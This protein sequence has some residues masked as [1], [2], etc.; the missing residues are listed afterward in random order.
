MS[1]GV[2]LQM[3]VDATKRSSTSRVVGVKISRGIIEFASRQTETQEYVVENKSDREK[4]V[5]VEH[6]RR[7][8]DWKLVETP[9]PTEK[10]DAVYRFRAEIP[11]GKQ[12]KL[13]VNDQTTTANGVVIADLGP[14]D[15][16]RYVAM[17]EMPGKAKDALA[18]AA[19]M[20]RSVFE[21][22]RAIEERK[23][24]I[25]EMTAEQNRIRENMKSVQQTSD[26][27]QRLLKKLNDQESAI[28]KLQ[29]EIDGLTTDLNTQRKAFEDYVSKLEI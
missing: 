1:F 8:G 19:E 13:V 28:E 26:Y 11:A 23:G 27:A 6:P 12:S 14:E 18:K 21:T 29:G 3:T 24:R 7:G 17:G 25:A 20:K 22:T 9:E 15:L 10:T 5:I 4:T 16:A 2:D